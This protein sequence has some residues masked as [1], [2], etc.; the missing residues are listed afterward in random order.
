MTAEYRGH[1]ASFQVEF[2]E[3]VKQVDRLPADFRDGVHADLTQRGLPSARGL[4]F[5]ND[6]TK[7]RACLRWRARAQRSGH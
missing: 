5:I 4:L 1:A 2:M 6:G 7:A 3:V